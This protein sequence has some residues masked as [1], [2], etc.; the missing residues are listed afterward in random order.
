M[1]DLQLQM[2]DLQLLMVDLQ[3]QFQFNIARSNLTNTVVSIRRHIY[4]ER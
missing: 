4:T 2:V 3:L 1:V